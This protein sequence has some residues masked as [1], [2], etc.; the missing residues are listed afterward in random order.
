[1]I[2]W[3]WNT[4]ILKQ[5]EH[6]EIKCPICLHKGSIT[7]FLMCRVYHFFFIPFFPD[8]KYI[9]SICKHCKEEINEVDVEKEDRKLF[10]TKSYPEH[11]SI[12]S[13]TGTFLLLV[14]IIYFSLR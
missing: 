5:V 4:N 9:Y 13:W 11:I 8:S 12:Q 10:N 1:M 6:K 14:I 7:I 3:G 2:L